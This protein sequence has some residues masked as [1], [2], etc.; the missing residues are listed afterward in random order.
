M[1]GLLKVLALAYLSLAV[2]LPD[3]NRDDDYEED[4]IITRDVCTQSSRYIYNSYSFSHY[5][6]RYI[7]LLRH[8]KSPSLQHHFLSR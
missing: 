4:D 2:A 6:I 3:H 5:N 8:L 7:L 1:R